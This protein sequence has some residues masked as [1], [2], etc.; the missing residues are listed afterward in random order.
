MLIEQIVQD[1]EAIVGADNVS[2]DTADRILHAFDAT[3]GHFL[4]EVVVHA[5]TTDQVSR[6]VRLAHEHRIP[7]LPRG[8]GSGFTGGSLPIKGGIVLVLTRM[9]RILEIDPDNLTA[10]VEPGVITARLQQEV[11]RLG[12]F[13]PPDPA[14]K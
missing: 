7:I 2:T 1:L 8:A 3:Q 4:P 12:L 10:T 13:Y 5:T 11:E 6:V 14:S 9:N